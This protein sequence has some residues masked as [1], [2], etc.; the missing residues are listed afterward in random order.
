MTQLHQFSI[1]HGGA[2]ILPEFIWLKKT[3]FDKENEIR[4][5]SQGFSRQTFNSIH[6]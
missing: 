4:Y 3:F 5:L 2:K 1:K 6:D